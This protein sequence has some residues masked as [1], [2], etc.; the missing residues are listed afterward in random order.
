MS[1]AVCKSAKSQNPAEREAK[2]GSAGEPSFTF[3]GKPLIERISRTWRGWRERWS[4]RWCRLSRGERPV[5]LEP[6]YD[7]EHAGRCKPNDERISLIELA[8]E[9]AC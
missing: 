3:L 9:R 1:R 6:V 2:N 7:G 5:T 4:D 8:C